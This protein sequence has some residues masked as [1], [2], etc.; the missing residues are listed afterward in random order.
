MVEGLSPIFTSN[1]EPIL[2]QWLEF[3]K[4]IAISQVTTDRI[5][6]HLRWLRTEYQP[7]CVTGSSPQSDRKHLYHP[8]NFLASGERRVYP[9]QPDD[10]DARVKSSEPEIEPIIWEEG[11]VLLKACEYSVEAKTGDYPQV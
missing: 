2:K 3:Q 6:E 7:R 1:D 8:Q 4:E 11:E 10:R 5:R 9:S